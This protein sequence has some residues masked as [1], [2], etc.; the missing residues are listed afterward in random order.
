MNRLLNMMDNKQFDDKWKEASGGAP[1][2]ERSVF[3]PFGDRPKTQRQFILHSEFEYIS[4]LAKKH[5]VKEAIEIGCGRGTIALYLNKYL[6]VSVVAA[7]ISDEAVNLARENFSL[8]KG[9]GKVI[10]ADAGHLPFP[11]ATFDMTVSIGLLEH[12]E[13]YTSLIQ[14]QYRVLKSGGIMVSLN[15]PKKNSIQVLNNIYRFFLNLLGFSTFLKKDYFRNSDTPEMYSKIAKEA[16]FIEVETFYCNPFPLFTPIPKFCERI[17]VVLYR[18]IYG[19][20]RLF[21]KYP[22]KGS[23]L[24]SQEHF[25]VGIKK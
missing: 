2:E 14:E 11:E 25:L 1:F 18:L 15:I 13:D 10:M 17:L 9:E 21:M 7:D 8:H 22:F 12:L 16:G 19:T 5:R 4:S 24:L 20:R 23:Q 6:G 3:V